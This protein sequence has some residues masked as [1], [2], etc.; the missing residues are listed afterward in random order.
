MTSLPHEA[1][2]ALLPFL[3]RIVRDAEG[4][5]IIQEVKKSLSFSLD[6]RGTA[7][8][9]EIA[10]CH[11]ES[12][13]PV[14]PQRREAFHDYTQEED[15]LVVLKLSKDR[16]APPLPALIPTPEPPPSWLEHFVGDTFWEGPCTM[17]LDVPGLQ[18]AFETAVKREDPEKEEPKQKDMEQKNAEQETLWDRTIRL[19]QTIRYASLQEFMTGSPLRALKSE[20]AEYTDRVCSFVQGLEH[21]PPG[22]D[23]P[24]QRLRASCLLEW[25]TMF[26]PK[27]VVNSFFALRAF[28]L[29]T[30]LVHHDIS[31]ANMMVESVF[32]EP[33]DLPPA[34]AGEDDWVNALTSPAHC[35]LRCR[36][37]DC[38]FAKAFGTERTPQG[39]MNYIN[40]QD[41]RQ[42]V[43]NHQKDARHLMFPHRE[44]LF[45]GPAREALRRLAE[46][47]GT[48]P[49][50]KECPPS[51]FIMDWDGWFF[52]VL[53][54]IL[55]V[56]SSLLRKNSF[57]RAQRSALRMDSK[58]PM[59][60]ALY[61]AKYLWYSLPMELF[62]DSFRP[63]HRIQDPRVRRLRDMLWD[64]FSVL[65]LVR[66]FMRDYHQNE[67]SLFRKDP[68]RWKKEGVHRLSLALQTL[69]P[70]VRELD[71]QQARC[72]EL[73]MSEE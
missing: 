3:H 47:T 7:I 50:G 25:E 5:A 56:S 23:M 37:L 68:E 67:E 32:L 11:P 66:D 46:E 49:P 27:A 44:P 38:D 14:H 26:L 35:L 31:G 20:M 33:E 29:G 42:L 1:L 63:S 53:R 12:S 52:L 6:S 51:H 43:Y 10:L 16:V 8:K 71:P 4:R 28:H 59:D 15:S 72:C 61:N 13:F 54:R 30:G 70:V 24:T 65:F 40:M 57:L 39:T 45:Q 34:E 48:A 60:P 2:G 22:K 62:M 69:L 58:N 41:H 17:D 36:L 9:C 55:P 64:V 73:W 21:P 18:E 19:L